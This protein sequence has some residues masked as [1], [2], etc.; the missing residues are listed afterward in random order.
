MQTKTLT[1]IL[2]KEEE[3]Y[4]AECLEVGTIDQ[5]NTIEEAIENLREATKL[6]LEESSTVETPTKFI[7]T[8]EVTYG[9]L[10]YA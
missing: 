4:I 5:G 1:V 2:H 3:M 10:S 9:E 7:T 8:M 6:F